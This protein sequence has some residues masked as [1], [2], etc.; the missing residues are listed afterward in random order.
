MHKMKGVTIIIRY[1]FSYYEFADDSA[2]NEIYSHRKMVG[3]EL[4]ILCNITIIKR[5]SKIYI[6]DNDAL[7]SLSRG[8]R[9]HRFANN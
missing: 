9:L 6:I 4:E 3:L 2:L 7:Y 8:Q 5:G 1:H